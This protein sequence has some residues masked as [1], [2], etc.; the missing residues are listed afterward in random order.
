MSDHCAAHEVPGAPDCHC[1]S[2]SS[3]TLVAGARRIALA[4]APNAGKTSIYNALTGLRAK[5]GNYPGVT[6]TRSLGTCRIGETDLTIEDL[7]GAYSLDPISPDEQIV[8]E[9]LDGHHASVKA[10]DALIVVL[11]S[12]TLR[13][14]MA[15]LA[16]A[17]QL[18]LPTCLVITMTDEL[19]KRAG[20]LDVEALGR[21]LGVPAIRV[22]GHR[23][24]GIPELRE[25]LADT[26]AWPSSP[27][28]PPTDPAEFASWADSILEAADF[29]PPHE[30][31]TTAAIDRVLLHPVAG[32]IVFFAI[33]FFFFQAIFSWAEPLKDGRVCRTA[34]V[35]GSWI[36]L[37]GQAEDGDPSVGGDHPST[38]K[39]V[40]N[41]VHCPSGHVLVEC[42]SRPRQGRLVADA[43]QRLKK[44]IGVLCQATAAH[45]SGTLQVWTG[46]ADVR[47]GDDLVCVDS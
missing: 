10:P 31:R 7:P 30:D 15:F 37:V 1:G 19:T 9:V 28:A 25:R 44:H 34:D 17:L 40:Q 35:V 6:V 23:G 3:K 18:G 11:D 21:A 32:T 42:A 45:I 41:R 8:R 33:M 4:G 20:H 2:S 36:A 22:L 5:T 47:G 27:I 43:A 13:R 16:K 29:Q 24:I 26:A 39:L 38:G 46:I 12:T 14:G